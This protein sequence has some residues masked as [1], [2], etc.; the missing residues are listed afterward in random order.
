MPLTGS[1]IRGLL[2][3]AYADVVLEMETPLLT[4]HSE[5]EVELQN[6]DLEEGKI[7]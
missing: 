1:R 4:E 5:S 3:G 6:S 7:F 2:K